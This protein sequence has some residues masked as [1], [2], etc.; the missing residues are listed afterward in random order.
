MSKDKKEDRSDNLNKLIDDINKNFGVGSVTNMEDRIE[1]IEF[2][3]TGCVGIDNILGGGF[4]KGRVTEIYGAPSSSKTTLTI[5]A[6]AEAQKEGLV[7]FIDAENAF[8]VYYARNLGL[9]TG[10]D[11]WLISQPNSGELAFSIA[12]KLITS[13]L[14]SM[15]V[16]DS[17]AALTPKAEIEGDY[18]D[19]KMGLHARLMSQA[20]RKL[21]SIIN[22][23]NTVVIFTNQKRIKLG[24]MFGN[25]ETTT[26]GEALKFYASQRLELSRIGQNKEGEEVVSNKIR[27]KVVKNK[28]APPFKQTEFDVVFGKGIDKIADILDLAVELDIVKKSGSWYSYEETKL[29]QGRSAVVDL[30]RDNPEIVEEVELKVRKELKL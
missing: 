26:G 30:F 12:E 17:V 28:V 1:G 27:A 29:G 24:V 5:H 16:I 4:A 18:G 22:K 8:D 9:K 11:D 3:S 7:G 21:A 15:I 20:M 25:P 10:K 2:I 23:S 13:N 14:F 19:S 6:M